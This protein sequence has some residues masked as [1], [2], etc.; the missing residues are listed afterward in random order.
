M[1]INEYYNDFMQ[2]IY[3]ESGAVNDFYESIF[4]NLMCEFLTEHAIIDEFVYVGYKKVR[5]G[6]RLDAWC[7]N[8]ET[9]TLNLFI[10]DFRFENTL[11]SLTQTDV[12]KAL[13]QL[14]RFFV[15]NLK[16]KYYK[17]LEESAPYYE[18]AYE[19]NKRS[20]S[21][22]KVR[23]FLLSNAELSNR[24]VSI[25]SHNING[26]ECSYDIWDI[27]RR[28][29]IE[30]SGHAREDV[31]LDL[32]TIN[33]KGVP[34]LPAFSDTNDCKSYLIV[35]PGTFISDLYEEYGER[36]LEQNVRTFLQ[37]RGNVNK[38]IRNTILNEPS[39]FF[40][41]N[42][43]LSATA[44]KIIL[45][46]NNNA[47][48]SIT[49]LQIVNGGQT[50]ASIFTAKKKSKAD[51]SEV[52]V[53]VKLTVVSPEL[54]DTIVPRI[55]EYANT[56]NKVSAADF[57]SNHPFYLRMEDMSRRLWAPSPDDNFR[58]THWFF[59][60]T[61]GQYA[62]AQANLTPSEKKSFLIRNPRNQ[63]FTKTDLAKYI[64]TFKIQPHT[65]SMGS[66]KNFAKVANFIGKKW[67]TNENQFNELYFKR[68]IAKAIL[69]RN[70]DKL[71]MKQSWYGGYKANI[72]TYA[73]AK[74]SSMLNAIGK[75]PDLDLIWK[76]QKLSSKLESALLEISNIVNTQIQATPDG[77]TNVTE[78]CKRE[79]C[80]LKVKEL[81]VSPD[82]IRTIPELAEIGEDPQIRKEAEQD[83]KL[84]NRINNQKYVV[85]RGAEHWKM[86]SQWGVKNRLLSSKDMGILET[87]CK[88]PNKLPSEKQSI[89]L[90]EIEKRLIKEGCPIE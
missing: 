12:T 11:Q 49:N 63:M 70:L 15:E 19:I 10:S 28:F 43:G 47:I 39:M 45:N 83:Q 25:D 23:F 34:C 4:T 6:I 61:R 66:Q 81:Y 75:M 42:N 14:E 78:W 24:V 74:F 85:E 57:F 60:R 3:S 22:S 36:L 64:N 2:H 87:A 82:I 59:E 69:F 38:G 79:G 46:D 26:Y 68:L 17:S 56:Q 88:I 50:T 18:A 20:A 65:V 77:I 37:F 54:V 80:W 58:E 52:F 90:I 30:T 44:E 13:K 84:I 62:N 48:R 21:I 89:V 1:D 31:V 33:P 27:S 8:D 72:V 7:Y 76:N 55:S 67:E 71:I 40:A 73:L 29:R 16:E 51:L 9:E 35:L 5:Q 41:Y 86:I 32:R 53:Q